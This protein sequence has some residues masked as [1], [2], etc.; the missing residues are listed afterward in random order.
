[1]EN[2]TQSHQ[3]NLLIDVAPWGKSVDTVT[4]GYSTPH[5]HVADFPARGAPKM[6]TDHPVY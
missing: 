6:L 2:Y 4:M 5:L 1:M 3:G